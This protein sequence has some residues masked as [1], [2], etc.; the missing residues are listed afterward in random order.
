MLWFESHKI[1]LY[2]HPLYSLYLKLTEHIYVDMKHKFHIMYPDVV[3]M[4]KA[5][6]TINSRLAKVLSHVWEETKNVF[7]KT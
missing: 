1:T 2:K 3:N 7:L 4:K 5:P 6:E